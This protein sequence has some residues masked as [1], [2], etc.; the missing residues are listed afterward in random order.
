MMS[1][2]SDSGHTPFGDIFISESPDML[3]WGKHRHMMGK[4]PEWW[5]SV[6]IGGGAAPIETS[7]GW[8]LIYHGVLTSCSGYVYHFGAALLDLDDPQKVIARGSRY[9]M[10]PEMPYERYGDV[11]NVVFPC[12]T[13]CDAETGRIAVYY[14]CADTVTGVAFGYVDEIISYIKNN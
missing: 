10:A 2:P 14:G 7:E 1:R 13:L 5:Q 6:K 11:P 8:L 9:L 4:N 12:A 3:Y